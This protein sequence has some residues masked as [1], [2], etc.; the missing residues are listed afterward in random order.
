[1]YQRST[2]VPVAVDSDL[3]AVLQKHARDNKLHI[4]TVIGDLLRMAAESVFAVPERKAQR[5]DEMNLNLLRAIAACSSEGPP[6]K[7]DLLK[8]LR[9]APMTLSSRLQVVVGMGLV[10]DKGKRRNN[11]EPRGAPPTTWGITANG[12]L[13]LDEAGDA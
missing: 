3:Y 10:E 8:V 6:S 12:Q 5:V 7:T 13:I 9:W 11:L 4:Q 1:M 2:I